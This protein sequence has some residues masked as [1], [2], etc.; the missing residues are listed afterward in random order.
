MAEYCKSCADKLG[1]DFEGLK[2][3]EFCEGCKTKGYDFNTKD[4]LVLALIVVV[5]ILIFGF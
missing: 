2:G 4:K 5:L 3:N 1:L